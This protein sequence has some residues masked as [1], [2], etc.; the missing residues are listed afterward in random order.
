ML[1]IVST[2]IGNH[3]QED[4]VTGPSGINANRAPAPSTHADTQWQPSPRFKGIGPE[5]RSIGSEDTER[6]LN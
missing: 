4:Q 1:N 3:I 5:A 6:I 2:E